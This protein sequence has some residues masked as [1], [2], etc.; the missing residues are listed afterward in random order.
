MFFPLGL[1]LCDTCGAG[2]SVPFQAIAQQGGQ[3]GI[4]F[5]KGLPTGWEM[6]KVLAGRVACDKCAPKAAEEEAPPSKLIVTH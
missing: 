2:A 6:S 3:Q 1:L 5:P 4:A